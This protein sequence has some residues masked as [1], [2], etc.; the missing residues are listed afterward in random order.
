MLEPSICYSIFMKELRLTDFDA[1][2]FD[3]EGTLADT[4]P[5]H[6]NTRITAF[7]QHGFGHITRDQHELGPTYGSSHFDILGG[8]LHAAEEIDNSV[9]FHQNQ[10]VLDVIATKAALFQAEAAKG[11]EVM[12]GAIQFVELIAPH[13]LGKMALVTSSEEGFIFPFIERYNLEEYFPKRLVIG[14]ESIIAEGL[15]PKPSG[16]PYMLAIQ[17]MKAKN[18]LVFE[19]TVPGVASAKRAGATVI[20]LGFDAANS[21]LFRADKLE[22]PPDMVVDDYSDAASLLK[23]K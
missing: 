15:T 8:I 23:L 16:D 21:K 14:H 18:M 17:R 11:F 5:T 19:D 2:A 6:H 1:V 12:P 7:E 20:A 13:F 10:T 9:P 4:V 3:V 22:F